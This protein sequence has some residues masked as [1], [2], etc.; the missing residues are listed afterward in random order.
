M[1]TLDI[2]FNVDTSALAN[3]MKEAAALINSAFQ[4][5]PIKKDDIH[6]PMTEMF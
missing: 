5:T 2:G 3:G 6:K 1:E 4:N